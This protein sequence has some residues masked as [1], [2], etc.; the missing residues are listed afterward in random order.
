MKKNRKKKKEN[1]YKPRNNPPGN[2]SRMFE[3]N[4]EGKRGIIDLVEKGVCNG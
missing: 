4:K 1:G 3:N 2:R